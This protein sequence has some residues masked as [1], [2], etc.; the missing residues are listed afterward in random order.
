MMSEPKAEYVV[1]DK[2]A[3]WVVT[4]C[5]WKVTILKGVAWRETSCMIET[6]ISPSNIWRFCPF[7]GKPIK[8]TT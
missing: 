4:V 6:L 2:H 3:D 1:Y 5:E 8:V 7:C